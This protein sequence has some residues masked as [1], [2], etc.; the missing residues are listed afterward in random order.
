MAKS[1]HG[2]LH[3]DRTVLGRLAWLLPLALE[4]KGSRGTASSGSGTI[5]LVLILVS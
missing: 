3:K 2:Q 1:T 5:A 4:F